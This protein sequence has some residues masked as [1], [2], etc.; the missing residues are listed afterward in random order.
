MFLFGY[1][2]ITLPADRRP[3]FPSRCVVCGKAS[4]A[5]EKVYSTPANGHPLRLLTWTT[6]DAPAHPACARVLLRAHYF[7]FCVLGAV[8]LLIIPVLSLILGAGGRG[9]ALSIAVMYSV[10]MVPAYFWVRRRLMR[11]NP[12]PFRFESSWGK[13][14]YAFIDKAYAGEFARLNDSVIDPS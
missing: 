6:L 4:G 8:S 9:T 5:F 12:V 13:T 11:N 1:F 2:V 10:L 14:S 7:R 3:L